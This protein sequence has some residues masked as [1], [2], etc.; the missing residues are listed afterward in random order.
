MK[1]KGRET[2]VDRLHALRGNY[3]RPA[4]QKRCSKKKIGHRALNNMW[5]PGVRLA[6]PQSLMHCVSKS[7]AVFKW[8]VALLTETIQ[9]IFLSAL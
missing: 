8:F 1:G 2:S 9:V 5:R 3:S 6:V 4:V 7:S